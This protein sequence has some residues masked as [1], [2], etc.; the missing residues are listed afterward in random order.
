MAHVCGCGRSP[1]GFCHGYHALSEELWQAKLN[2]M[3]REEQE[4][5]DELDDIDEVHNVSDQGG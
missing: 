2:E 3:I 4:L 5:K 1:D